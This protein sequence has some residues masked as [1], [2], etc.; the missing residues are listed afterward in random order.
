MKRVLI[1]AIVIVAAAAVLGMVRSRGSI[2]HGF[3][4]NVG[5]SDDDSQGEVRDEIRKSFQLQPGAQI[6]VQGINSSV[7]IETSDTKTAEV[8][9]LRTA[10]SKDSLARREITIEQTADGLVVR[11][12][13]S[14]NLGFF[15]H[16]F[17]HNP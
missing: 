9:V 7:E 3:S 1:I 14:H 6:Q 16:L 15:D 13:E 10:D 4:F 5:T 12:Q 11:G 8:Y 2:R 17:G